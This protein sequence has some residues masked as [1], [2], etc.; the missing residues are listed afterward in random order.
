MAALSRPGG[1]IPPNQCGETGGSGEEGRPRLKRASAQGP[2]CLGEGWEGARASI[3]SLA[4][5][6]ALRRSIRS[7]GGPAPAL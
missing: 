4:S 1:A 5:V 2:A 3:A 6:P 7:A